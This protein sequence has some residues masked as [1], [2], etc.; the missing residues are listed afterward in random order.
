MNVGQVD[1]YLNTSRLF[2]G[3]I[4]VL[5][6]VDSAKVGGKM[7]VGDRISSGDQQ[8]VIGAVAHQGSRNFEVL[9]IKSELDNL[10]IYIQGSLM[11]RRLIFISRRFCKFSVM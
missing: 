3:E 8:S 4:K 11:A 1:G 2:D 7:L 10:K 5:S 6:M 9:E